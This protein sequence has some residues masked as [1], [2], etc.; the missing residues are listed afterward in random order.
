MPA[1]KNVCTASDGRGALT[2]KVG[3][4][5]TR[6]E[7]ELA[8]AACTPPPPPGEEAF[9]CQGIQLETLDSDNDGVLSP[10]EATEAV[11]T[12]LPKVVERVAWVQQCLRPTEQTYDS[13]DAAA[14]M[15]GDSG[16]V[17]V[18]LINHK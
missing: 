6:L 5:T 2:L 17:S 18:I 8:S 7:C 13:S 3:G 9:A 15:G 16:T 12:T 11:A 1:Y 10:A 4:V 14:T